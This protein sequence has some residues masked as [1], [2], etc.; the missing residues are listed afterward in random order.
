MMSKTNNQTITYALGTFRSP[1][2]EEFLGRRAILPKAQ[3]LYVQ[4]CQCV[5]KNINIHTC[6]TTIACILKKKGQLIIAAQLSV[7]HH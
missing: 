7:C 3:N 1:E 6:V 5:L 4:L 2:V